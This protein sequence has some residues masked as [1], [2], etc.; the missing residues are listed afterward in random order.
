MT[1]QVSLDVIKGTTTILFDNSFYKGSRF[2]QTMEQ[3]HLAP[4]FLI[5]MPQLNDPN[6]NRTVVLILEHN[7]DGSLG[8]VI[9]NPI[10]FSISF[11][12]EEDKEISIDNNIFVGGPVARN[13]AMVIHGEGFMCEHTQELTKGLYLSGPSIAIPQLVQQTE[14]PYRLALGYSGWAPKQLA[15]EMAEGSWLTC[16]VTAELALNVEPEK[17][18]ETVI[19]SMGIDP[20]ML[21]PSG[22]IQ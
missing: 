3:E 20:M 5:A 15:D 12:F 6:F 11:Q 17:Q 7:N 8:L 14:V 13:V 18:W 10:P 4:G 1:L 9:N 19:R 22:M 2:M 16:P 21:I